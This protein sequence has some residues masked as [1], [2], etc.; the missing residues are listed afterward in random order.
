M[1]SNLF[2]PGERRIQVARHRS[3]YFPARMGERCKERY[4]KPSNVV[5]VTT[6]SSGGVVG[7][8][9]NVVRVGVCRH[10]VRRQHPRQ[11]FCV[12]VWTRRAYIHSQSHHMRGYTVKV[13]LFVEFLFLMTVLLNP[14]SSGFPTTFCFFLSPSPWDS[15]S[16][17]SFNFSQ[18]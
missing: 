7:R 9:V 5:N 10:L 4:V 14:W 12:Q 1:Y 11:R 2:H 15:S 3:G 6:P 8:R 17:C 13:E 18:H 16:G